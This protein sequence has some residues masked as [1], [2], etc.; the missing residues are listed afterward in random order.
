LLPW[1][2]QDSNDQKSEKWLSGGFQNL[3]IA[4]GARKKLTWFLK[5]LESFG[6]ILGYVVKAV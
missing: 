1:K 5:A 2:K 6:E 4:R 3:A